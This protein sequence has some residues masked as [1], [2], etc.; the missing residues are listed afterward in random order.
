MKRAKAELSV[1]RESGTII[2][3]LTQRQ[4][5][6]WQNLLLSGKKG[7]GFMYAMKRLLSWGSYRQDDQKQGILYD[8]LE[9]YMG[10][11]WLVLSWK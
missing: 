9:V 2:F 6:K 3:I 4:A 11:L 5:E 10:F 8:C 1:A 7:K